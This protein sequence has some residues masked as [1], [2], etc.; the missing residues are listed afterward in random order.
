MKIKID[1]VKSGYIADF[2]ELAGSPPIG[3]GKTKV[4]TVVCLFARNKSNLSKLDFNVV[5]INGKLWRGLKDGRKRN[6]YMCGS[7]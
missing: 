2:I 1:K 7:Y 6:L 3:S 5:E 4:E